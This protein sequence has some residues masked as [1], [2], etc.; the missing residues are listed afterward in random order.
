MGFSHNSKTHFLW[1]E[2]SWSF[3]P[4]KIGI[5]VVFSR[6]FVQNCL[7]IATESVRMII[8]AKILYKLILFSD[9]LGINCPKQMN[10]LKTKVVSELK[11]YCDE[12]QKTNNKKDE[13]E[14]VHVD[15]CR[16]SNLLL[17]LAPLRSLQ[18]DVLE[19][20]F[21]AGLIGNVQIDSVVP[22]ILKMETSE[23]QTQFGGKLKNIENYW[24]TRPT[25]SHGR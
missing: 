10:K 23:Y 3:L 18:P 15:H 6:V 12:K 17:I 9:Q 4:L 11:Q 22:Y 16:F 2:I 14:D 20:L 24:S 25:Q 21:F 7:K 8:L 5:F 1:M 13:N 19:E